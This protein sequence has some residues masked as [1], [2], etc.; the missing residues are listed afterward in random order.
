MGKMTQVL[1]DLQNPHPARAVKKISDW[2]IQKENKV[3]TRVARCRLAHHS[4]GELFGVAIA[5]S[6]LE[7]AEIVI[8]KI[9]RILGGRD[10]QFRVPKVVIGGIHRVGSRCT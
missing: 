5:Q 10:T 7:M 1:Y 4:G 9:D 8:G 2:N 6:L 3:C